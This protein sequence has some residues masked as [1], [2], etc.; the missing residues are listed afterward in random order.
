VVVGLRSRS[1]RSAAAAIA[2]AAAEEKEVMLLDAV[3]SGVSEEEDVG[4]VSLAEQ[5]RIIM[6]Q[7][8]R[9]LRVPILS[10]DVQWKGENRRM[11]MTYLKQTQLEGTGLFLGENVKQ[12]DVLAEFTG[13]LMSVAASSMHATDKTGFL[14]IPGGVKSKGTHI[15]G[16]LHPAAE[17]Y[18]A[19]S[20]N[21][22]LSDFGH[23]GRCVSFRIVF[24]EIV[25]CDQKRNT[26]VM[27]WHDSGWEVSA[28]TLSTFCSLAKLQA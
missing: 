4:S 5:W 22:N 20:L 16:S 11:R 9:W 27:G 8:K 17:R 14:K 10:H 12:G 25:H 23:K 2:A 1:T 28:T 19:D 18:A 7:G 3:D 24:I 26:N 21:I 13:E 15:D 6:F